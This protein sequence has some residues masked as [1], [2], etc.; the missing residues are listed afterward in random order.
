[1][2]ENFG[3]GPSVLSPEQGKAIEFLQSIGLATAAGHIRDAITL[4][5]ATDKGAMKLHSLRQLVAHLVR[6]VDSDLRDCLR[7][8]DRPNGKN[9]H[10]SDV[11]SICG[12]LEFPR[13]LGDQWHSLRKEELQK[14][15]HYRKASDSIADHNQL[16]GLLSR[17]VSLVNSIDGNW[18][19][20][21]A[22]WAAKADELLR[23]KRFAELH[24]C[25]PRMYLAYHTLLVSGGYM[26][27]DV[28]SQKGY[29]K[30]ILESP[31]FRYS[32]T[33]KA[34]EFGHMLHWPQSLFLAIWS[35]GTDQVHSALFHKFMLE[36]DI[37]HS[38][39]Q[40]HYAEALTNT[41]AHLGT[42]GRTVIRRL[43]SAVAQTGAP[44]GSL[45]EYNYKK[46]ALSLLASGEEQLGLQLS[47]SLLRFSVTRTSDLTQ[48][49]CSV[50]PSTARGICMAIAN[51]SDVVPATL[52]L[53]RS[54][55]MALRK[56][57]KQSETQD[58]SYD[59]IYDYDGSSIWCEGLD[60]EA[61]EREHD[62]RVVLVQGLRNLLFKILQHEVAPVH[63]V[64]SLLL[65]AR[66]PL[67]VRL[68]L[69]VARHDPL[70]L[71]GLVL[72]LAS[73]RNAG[74]ALYDCQLDYYTALT[75]VKDS[76]GEA[77]IR[78]IADAISTIEWDETLDDSRRSIAVA[79]RLEVLRDRLP[80]DLVEVLDRHWE[81]AGVPPI[82]YIERRRPRDLVFDNGETVRYGEDLTP[83]ETVAK[84]MQTLG[85]FEASG[86]AGAWNFP[87]CGISMEVVAGNPT[88]WGEVASHVVA[89]GEHN[90]ALVFA[91]IQ[92]FSDMLSLRTAK[93]GGATAT[94]LLELAELGF[95]PKVVE[96]LPSPDSET[97]ETFTV[98]L[99]KA[100]LRLLEQLLGSEASC[101]SD[102]KKR[103][104]P[105]VWGILVAMAASNQPDT[106]DD[107]RALLEASCLHTLAINTVRGK[108]FELLRNYEVWMRDAN[109][110]SSESVARNKRVESQLDFLLS[111]RSPIVRCQV[112]VHLDYL[113]AAH[114]DWFM[115]RLENLLP[116]AEDR[117][118]EFE[119][120][121][122]G[123]SKWCRPR[124]LDLPRLLTRA[125]ERA[126]TLLTA[127]SDADAEKLYSAWRGLHTIWV[128]YVNGECAFDVPVGL[129]GRLFGG[130]K[131]EGA[132]PKVRGQLIASI[133]SHFRGE[134][135]VA[136][137]REQLDKLW[138]WRLEVIA[139]T[140]QESR[141]LFAPETASFAEWHS[142]GV[143]DSTSAFNRIRKGWQL[144][145][146][147]REDRL[148]FEFLEVL[149]NLPI[150]ELDVAVSCVELLFNAGNDS[151]T[152]QEREVRKLFQRCSELAL[153]TSTRAYSKD[154]ARKMHA[155]G[156]TSLR[157]FTSCFRSGAKCRPVEI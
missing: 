103:W 143:T 99:Q 57:K 10:Q 145:G 26:S 62:A 142:A 1:M 135:L 85:A 44:L 31:L 69:K 33:P 96:D 28:L 61:D 105:K 123:Y 63:R 110:Q 94:A 25:T 124:C 130:S 129:L 2:S 38:Q 122:E 22:I 95:S 126:V 72:E 5:G 79:C 81:K 58:I 20:W 98:W 100:S 29:L 104:E 155:A 42:N 54:L 133:G 127:A 101:T 46:L 151:M 19:N 68:A 150:D 111:D 64:V 144:T 12:L 109:D 35:E 119:A 84:F 117:Q 106:E 23:S 34:K 118:A 37:R 113:Y 91:L 93:V 75:E 82:T 36:N 112:G 3:Y 45:E 53:G 137:Q 16:S 102:V 49:R 13:D 6:E 153:G 140:E 77:A 156:W 55:R 17:L 108:S 11:D 47:R 107:A 115:S 43:A 87:S 147:P 131:N 146:A 74:I 121:W 141:H 15:T 89:S 125:H 86:R 41:V 8:G 88:R 48:P 56:G 9:A 30:E 116:I 128:P 50:S 39:V 148:P 27:R 92:S 138:N 76:L 73:G 32:E 139:E 157:K 71:R 21:Y 18:H 14:L 65:K 66:W 149:S 60:E 97:R 67:F 40:T 52:T 120:V 83:E 7:A 152:W 51:C 80:M 134:S 154:V 114:G 90:P 132:C 59:L 136:V 24:S 78:R 70:V 4:L